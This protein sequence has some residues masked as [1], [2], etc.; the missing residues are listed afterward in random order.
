MKF[1]A[2]KTNAVLRAPGTFECIVVA[3]GNSKPSTLSRSL[4]DN[5]E[6]IA[7]GVISKK[8]LVLGKR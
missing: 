5:D 4:T 6:G 7:R 2:F 1:G 8:I 3:I